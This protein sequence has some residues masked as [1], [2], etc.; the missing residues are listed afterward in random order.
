V[1][2]GCNWRP[3]ECTRMPSQICTSSNTA[4]LHTNTNET[5]SS[6]SSPPLGQPVPHAFHPTLV[7]KKN[8][9]WT[10]TDDVT[11]LNNVIKKDR[12]S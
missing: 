3:P 6:T 11:A 7:Q 8:P 2:P 1:T 12:K 9:L 4:Q 5:K 10:A